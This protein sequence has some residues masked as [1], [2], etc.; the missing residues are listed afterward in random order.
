MPNTI[1]MG[2]ECTRAT[3]NGLSNSA[4][5][6]TRRF[7]YPSDLVLKHK[8]GECICWLTVLADRMDIDINESV[9]HFLKKQKNY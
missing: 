9:D 1:G 3:A 2:T 5:F 7:L 8:L 4:L 6:I